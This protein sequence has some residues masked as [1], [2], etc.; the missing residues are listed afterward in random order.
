MAARAPTASLLCRC[1]RPIPPIHA[2]QGRMAPRCHCCQRS[3]LGEPC[4]PCVALNVERP[5]FVVCPP[6]TTPYQPPA[7]RG[8]LLPTGPGPV[9]RLPLPAKV[10]PARRQEVRAARQPLHGEARAGR[11]VQVCRAPGLLVKA[12]EPLPGRQQNNG[13]ILRVRLRFVLEVSHV[14]REPRKVPFRGA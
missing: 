9:P 2:W 12:E 8:Q 7:P 4:L 1:P 5:L 13:E 10:V 6:P 3:P 14:R 11:D